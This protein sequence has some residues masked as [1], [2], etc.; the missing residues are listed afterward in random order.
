VIAKETKR[1]T[2]QI[3]RETSEVIVDGGPL[4]AVAGGVQAVN[5]TLAIH[6]AWTEERLEAAEERLG[7]LELGQAAIREDIAGLTTRVGNLEVGFVGMRADMVRME[8][9]IRGDMATMETRLRGDM[10]TMETRIRSDFDKLAV[11][12]DKVISF[13]VKDEPRLDEVERETEKE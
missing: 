2:D 6:A 3:H 7:G 1:R 4:A 13:A 10:A 12:I 9:R 11:R 8:E 5:E